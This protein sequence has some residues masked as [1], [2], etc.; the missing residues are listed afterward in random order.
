MTDVIANLFVDVHPTKAKL[1]LFLDGSCFL[2]ASIGSV[3]TLPR[4]LLRV[5]ADGNTSS[6]W[7]ALYDRCNLR[8]DIAFHGI[9]AKT[10]PNM[11]Q[12]F[13]VSWWNSAVWKSFSASVEHFVCQ[14]SKYTWYL[15]GKFQISCELT[16]G[17]PR[18][19][20]RSSMAKAVSSTVELVNRVTSD[21]VNSFNFEICALGS[22][23]LPIELVP[24][25]DGW[26]R[27]W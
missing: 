23:C 3:Y 25:S 18:L 17:I 20:C 8:F 1:T 16:I 15:N 11:R 27:T 19:P 9:C 6:L 7:N 10:K 21:T 5:L 26:W 24:C 14:F 13:P 22:K 12:R 4:V 2:I